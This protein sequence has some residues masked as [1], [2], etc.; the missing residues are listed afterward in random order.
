MKNKA[1]KASP[2]TA[3]ERLNLSENTAGM[4]K[5]GGGGELQTTFTDNRVIHYSD[6]SQTSQ[7]RVVYHIKVSCLNSLVLIWL[8]NICWALSSWTLVVIF[9]LL[10]PHTKCVSLVIMFSNVMCSI[11][12]AKWHWRWKAN[13]WVRRG[14]VT[15]TV[16]VFWIPC[17]SQS[18]SSLF[19]SISGL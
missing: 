8:P 2:H 7:G 17:C 5:G 16:L 3:D 1:R 19:C 10:K 6:H 4:Y 9:S 15:Q 11:M 13:Q 14:K 18:H 12:P